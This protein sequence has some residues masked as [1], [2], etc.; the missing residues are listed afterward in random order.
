MQLT[1]DAFARD[2][3]YQRSSIMPACTGRRANNWSGSM[4]ENQWHS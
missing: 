4:D 2:E 1:D 3:E